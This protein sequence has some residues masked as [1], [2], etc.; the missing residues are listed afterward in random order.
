ML[1]CCFKEC[2]LEGLSIGTKR[3]LPIDY[4]ELWRV[5]PVLCVVITADSD[6]TVCYKIATIFSDVMAVFTLED[7]QIVWTDKSS[8]M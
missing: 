6:Q 4:K 1:L 8:G 7:E 5:N 2:A 3:L